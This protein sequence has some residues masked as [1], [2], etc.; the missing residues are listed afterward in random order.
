[1]EELLYLL[2]GWLLGLISPRII[3]S[4][5][6]KYFRRDLA[7]AIRSEA[8]DLQ[9]RVAI[10][11]FLLASK[12]GELSREYL[13]WLKPKLLR[14]EGNEPVESIRKLAE[15]LHAAPDDQLVVLAA[16]MRAEEGKGLSLKTF[17]A[18]LIEAS[19]GSILHFSP[20][21]QR[22]VHEFRNQLSVLNQE[23]ERAIESLRMTYD[24]SISNENHV[25]LKA[26]LVAKYQTIQG[27]C[28]RVADRLQAILEY[29]P[30][31]I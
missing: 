31:K 12:Y 18:S 23:I 14:Y 11:S 19:L 25:R 2:L 16:H 10:M 1:M 3:D 13:V 7:R 30:K 24:S 15:T 20:E 22:R 28:M 8:E 9:Y 27:M 4:I 17:S 5:Q 21:Y 26:D 29:D 6:A